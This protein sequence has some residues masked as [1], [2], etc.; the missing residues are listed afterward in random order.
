MSRDVEL[1][2]GLIQA[3]LTQAC[4]GICDLKTKIPVFLTSDKLLEL[5]LKCGKTQLRAMHKIRGEVEQENLDP[6][7]KNTEYR[8]R[9]EKMVE[10][11]K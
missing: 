1:L 11:V 4:K 2:Q 8:R 10:D 6:E 5:T 9:V 3:D 7:L